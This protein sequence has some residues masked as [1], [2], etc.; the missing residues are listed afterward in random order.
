MRLKANPS[1]RFRRA[2]KRRHFRERRSGTL[3]FSANGKGPVFPGE[4]FRLLSERPERR[5]GR[6]LRAAAPF[7]ACAS[8]DGTCLRSPLPARV[9]PRRDDADEPKVPVSRL[10]DRRPSLRQTNYTG[11]RKTKTGVA[12]HSGN[13]CRWARKRTAPVETTCNRRCIHPFATL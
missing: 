6:S 2:V 9:S 11:G 4:K 12:A 1:R 10:S 5:L 13:G 8:A 7:A 3:L